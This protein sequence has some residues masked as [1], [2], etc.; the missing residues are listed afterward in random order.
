MPDEIEAC[1]PYLTQQIELVDPKVI[2]T[3][4]FA[5]RFMLDNTAGILKVR[6]QLFPWN[7]RVVIPTFH[8]AAV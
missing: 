8:P 4:T 3:R 1:R 7:G 2:V 5:T 6:G